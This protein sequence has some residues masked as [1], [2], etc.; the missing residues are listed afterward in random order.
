M[1]S[2]V[3]ERVA[4]AVLLAAVP[5]P[6]FGPVVSR[7]FWQ[8]FPKA[9]QLLAVLLA[10][11]T[12]GLIL[13]AIAAPQWGI[14]LLCAVAVAMLAATHW[15]TRQ[16]RG[17]RR[18]WPPG[19]LRPFALEPWFDRNFFLRQ[20]QRLGSP[21]K[22]A[23]FV[24]PMA[25][26]VGLDEGLEFFREHEPSL[27][28]PPLPFGRFIPGG[29]LRHMAP[30]RHTTTKAMFR[31]ALV[32]EVYEPLEHFIRVHIRAE[33]AS[34]AQASI[35]S[36][37]AGIPPRRHLQRLVFVLWARLFFNIEPASS[38]FN[39]LRSLFKVIDIRNPTG[40][41]DATIRAALAG[42]RQLLRQQLTEQHAADS[43]RP[44][45]F[46][47]ALDRYCPGSVY[48]PMVIG[49][50]IYLMHTTWSDISGL[51]QWLMRM[52]TE[53]PAWAARLRLP[54]NTADTGEST[55]LP[56]PT[57]VVMETLRLE[58]SEYLY[59]VVIQDIAHKDF[60]IPRG[61]L[62]RLCVQESHRDPAVFD[63]PQAFDPDRFL[64]RIFTRRQYSPFGAGLRHTCLGEKLTMTVGRIFVEELTVGYKWKTM[65]DGP[66]EFSGWRHW[67][68]SSRW[69]VLLEPVS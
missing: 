33:L 48:D 2:S 19:S 67:R 18:Q 47:E 8:V 24:R 43:G 64:N 58:Q 56:L 12:A 7:Q 26:L 3:L 17:R 22:S 66:H 31:K 11:Y 10:G 59:R 57:R 35:A 16:G 32:G 46:L 63:D 50:L 1:L 53:N 45:S 37:T 61:W 38:D 39:R 62:V 42:I 14:R 34:M 23:Q 69:R 4:A 54:G 6:V 52:L 28:S 49:N 36:G 15:H 55:R 44:R 40:A 5:W 21:F 65:A 60:V 51:F 30:E 68:P 13:I 25:C 41:S 20:Y 9:G 27:S 29:F